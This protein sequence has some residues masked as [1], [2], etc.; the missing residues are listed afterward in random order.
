[1]IQVIEHNHKKI[2]QQA[3][4][5]NLDS[6]LSPK[7]RLIQKIV[8]QFD[9]FREN[10]DFM[11]MLR[12]ALPPDNPRIPLLMKRIRATMMNW[13]KDCLIEAYGKKVELYIWD[14]ALMFQGALREYTY[15]AVHENKDIDFQ[16][17]A[18]FVV[19]RFDAMIHHTRDLEPVLTSR[20]MGEYEAF[21]ADLEPESPEEQIDQLLEELQEKIKNVSM[22][23][24]ARQ[25]AILAIQSLQKEIHENEPRRF[26]IKSLLLYLAEIEE[27]KP[28]VH[29]V[30][31]VFKTLQTK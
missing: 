17:A 6:S 8:V 13:Y 2:L 19:E 15:L 3:V 30:E 22:R 7:E 16:S 28:L 5:V 27:C 26:L 29:R 20:E 14:L 12:K 23:E 31:A 11:I 4:N 1:M 10:K 24:G 25:E 21:E 9:G 18:R